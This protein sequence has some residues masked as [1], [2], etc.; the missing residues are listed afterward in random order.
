MK[1]R[2]EEEGRTEIKEKD[3]W[4]KRELY[5]EEEMEERRRRGKWVRTKMEEARRGKHR[6][7]KGRKRRRSRSRAESKAR[8]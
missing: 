4:K 2:G 7:A 5:K 1:K 8:R 6:V 3:G